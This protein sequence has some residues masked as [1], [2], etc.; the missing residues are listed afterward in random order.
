MRVPVNG[1]PAAGITHT[2]ERRHDWACEAASQALD[3]PVE[4]LEGE[5]TLQPA[6]DRGLVSVSGRISA[7]REATCDRC[8]EPC[9]RGADVNVRLLYAPEARDDE[10]FDGGEIELEAEQLD[11]GWYADGALDLGSVLGEA[12]ALELPARIH[13]A[14]TVECDKRTADLLA[15]AGTSGEAGHPAFAALRD[16]LA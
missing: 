2:I 16:K 9:V 4:V 11:L 15:T 3:G 5:L 12:L 13:C 10:S 1:I 8:G 7:S 14:N 6:S